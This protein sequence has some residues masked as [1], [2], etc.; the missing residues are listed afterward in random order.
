M[1]GECATWAGPDGCGVKRERG[2][3][4]TRSN[5]G[6]AESTFGGV[7]FRRARGR[8]REART[9]VERGDRAVGAR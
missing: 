5:A 1:R 7:S 2:G 8:R 4:C 6:L 3:I 9:Q